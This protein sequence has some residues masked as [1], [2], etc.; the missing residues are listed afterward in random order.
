MRDLVFTSLFLVMLG[1]ALRRAHLGL[2]LWA[3]SALFPPNDFLYGFARGLPF[4]KLS[5]ACTL[6]ALLADRRRDVSLDPLMVLLLL[7]V[8]YVSLAFAASEA[9]SGWGDDLYWRLVKV[10]IASLFIRFIAIDR[11]RLYSLIMA[12]GLAVGTG[13][14]DEGLKFLVTAGG[15]HSKGP[16]SW[17]DENITAAIV[18]MVIPLLIYLRRYLA[19]PL[20]RHT[21]LAVSV[22]T[23]AAVIGTY[24]RGGFIGLLTL[25]GLGFITAR[26][27]LLVLAVIA[28][29]AVVLVEA[30]PASWFQRIESTGHAEQDSSFMGRVIQWKILTLMA[31]DH[32][33]LGGGILTNTY[34]PVWQSYADRLGSELTFIPTPPPTKPY[35]SHS[36]FFQ[37][38]GENGFPGLALYLAVLWTAFRTTRRV[39][40]KARLS[41]STLWAADLAAALRVSLLL[42]CVTGAALPIPYLEFPYLLLGCVSALARIQ[43]AESR[44]APRRSPLGPAPIPPTSI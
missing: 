19:L 41:P 32:P 1:M 35:A 24:S 7:F 10:A 44:K 37:V 28:A 26:R 29:G 9:P 27:K 34:P 11:L 20:L 39:Q 42:Y 18:L 2:M 3:W 25:G 13:A 40:A 14:V 23:V 22:I 31:L 30:A 4:N 38:L 33:L 12:M 5:V 6:A 36:I 21:V 43:A 17:G 16:Q 8:A 15:H